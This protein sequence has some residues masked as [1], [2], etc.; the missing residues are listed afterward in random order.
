LTDTWY[1]S[2]WLLELPTCNPRYTSTAMLASLYYAVSLLRDA[3]ELR[4]V[5]LHLVGSQ[6]CPLLAEICT[7]GW[8]GTCCWTI[9]FSPSFNVVFFVLA[10][11]DSVESLVSNTEDLI[12]LRCYFHPWVGDR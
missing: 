12:D 8:K 4:A 7:V 3:P 10:G 2:R 5:A 1:I 6:A 9:M 11:Q